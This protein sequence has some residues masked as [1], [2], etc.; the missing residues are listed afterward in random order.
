VVL[1]VPASEDFADLFR[2]QYP[3]L[4]RLLSAMPPRRRACVVLCWLL[5]A[6]TSEAAAALGIADGT[7]RKH[8]DAAR[9]Q[10]TGDLVV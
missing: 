6:P 9:R 10:I 4:D 8:L 3:D 2:D 5:E 7:V 1:P